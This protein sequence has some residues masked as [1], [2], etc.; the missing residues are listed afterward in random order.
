MADEN[1]HD[2]LFSGQDFGKK[3]RKFQYFSKYKNR[4]FLPQVK[5]PIEYTVIIAIGVLLLV[6]IAY[7]IGIERGK[8]ISLKKYRMGQGSRL[9]QPVE[10]KD[11]TTISETGPFEEEEEEEEAEPSGILQETL[12]GEEEPQE[13][14]K[15]VSKIE[16]SV[17]T[18]Q[19]ASFKDREYAAEEMGKLAKMGLKAVYVRKGDWYQVYVTGYKTIEEARE[20]KEKLEE[21]YVDCFIKRV[22]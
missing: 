19:L 4:R 12:I 2:D 17:Y 15:S 13:A 10:L 21:I 9:L 22:K 11:L 7:A 5:I 14:K 16:D 3:G 18:I 6:I 8:A 20:A 1:I